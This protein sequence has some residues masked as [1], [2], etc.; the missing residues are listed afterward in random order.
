MTWLASKLSIQRS[1]RRSLPLTAERCD[2]A[3]V[4]VIEVRCGEIAAGEQNNRSHIGRDEIDRLLQEPVGQ[5]LRQPSGGKLFH[6]GFNRFRPRPQ[7]FPV[8]TGILRI[9]LASAGRPG[10][11][12]FPV[13]A[14]QQSGMGD[15][16]FEVLRF[17]LQQLPK[18]R[19]PSRTEEIRNYW[20]IQNNMAAATAP[21]VVRVAKDF[22]TKDPSRLISERP[23]VQ[24]LRLANRPRGVRKRVGCR[25]WVQTDLNVAVLEAAFDLEA[26]GSKVF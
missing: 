11:L 21:G 5:S 18:D 26:Q 1:L 12:E 16:Q 3:A 25:T 23:E 4:V 15:D 9:R 17:Q 20:N 13:P 7:A 2:H 19:L 10:N 14:I 22:G 8:W 24:R 6:R